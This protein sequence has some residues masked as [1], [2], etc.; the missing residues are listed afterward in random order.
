MGKGHWRGS[1]SIAR[2]GGI[3]F[4]EGGC[5]A[6]GWGREQTSYRPNVCRVQ[7][8]GREAENAG[9][10]TGP[11]VVRAKGA[12]PCRRA[13]AAGARKLKIGST[14]HGAGVNTMGARGCRQHRRASAAGAVWVWCAGSRACALP[15]GGSLHGAAARAA[16]RSVAQHAQRSTALTPGTHPCSPWSCERFR[17][18]RRGATHAGRMPAPPVPWAVP[19]RAA[20]PESRRTR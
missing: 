11:G 12:A 9:Q 14:R 20:P 5:M 2:S 13:Q 15:T 8:C 4:G 16:Q 17:C 3:S 7:R 18:R 10:E 1:N 6:D 19:V